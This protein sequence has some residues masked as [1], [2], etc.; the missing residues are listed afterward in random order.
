MKKHFSKLIAIA[1]F[2]CM[3]SPVMAQ[4]NVKFPDRPIRLVVPSTA[5]GDPDIIARLVAERMSQN[6]GQPIVIDNKPG[7]AGMIGV[8]NVA[9]SKPDGY[10]IGLVFQA[11]LTLSPQLLVNKLFDPLTDI[12]PVGLI[13]VTGNALMVPANSP[14]TSY[15]DLL[16]RA[17][18]NPGDISYG[19][20]GQGSAGHI[21]GEIMKKSA[22][23]DILHIPYKGSNESVLGMFGGEVEAVFGGWALT[24]RQLKAG[25]VRVLAVTSPT[26]ARMF[27]DVRTYQE[28]GIP[29]GLNSWFGLV[30]PA[31]VPEPIIKILEESLM[32]VVNQ[33]DVSSKLE[34]MGMEAQSSTAKQ[35]GERIN[36]DYK[37]WGMEIIELKIQPK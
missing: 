9:K 5:G 7:A 3:T 24:G 19:S 27:P 35:L 34:G 26:R 18:A 29:F 25:A 16:V 4:D 2:C 11:A 13:S 21:S 15:E 20:W 30:A 36:G 23:I 1:A 8:S 31:G 12:A 28:L 6:L 33:P 10:T 17:K 37:I 14:I 32:K 22:G